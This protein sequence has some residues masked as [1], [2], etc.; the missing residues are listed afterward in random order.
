LNDGKLDDS[1]SLL[2]SSDS[3]AA[4]FLEPSQVRRLVDA[5]SKHGRDMS[6]RIWALLWLEHWCRFFR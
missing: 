3:R 2:T 6:G 1:L 5:H 4:E